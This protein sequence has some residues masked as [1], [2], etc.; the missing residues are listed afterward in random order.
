MQPSSH[1]LKTNILIILGASLLALFSIAVK[2]SDITQMEDSNLQQAIN[3]DH[4][5]A[6]NKA[7]DQYRKPF[8]TLR[9]LGIKEHMTVVEITPGG[10]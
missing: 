4:R 7:R 10:E 1:H 2:A 9:W 8:E 6:D 5:S 3:G